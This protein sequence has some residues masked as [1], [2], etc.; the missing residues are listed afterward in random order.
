MRYVLAGMLL[1]LLSGHALGD[2]STGARS[3]DAV[4]KEWADEFQ[5]LDK[6]KK[7]TL[8]GKQRQLAIL[9]DLERAPCKTAQRFLLKLL[10]KR[11]TPGDHRLFALRSLVKMA[12][13]KTLGDVVAALCKAKD[14]TLWQAFG[15]FLGQSNE[16]AVRAWMTGKGLEAKRAD[17]LAACLEGLARRPDKETFA[18]VQ[19]LYAKHADGGDVDV[20]HRAL[21][22]M[23]RTSGADAKES[24]IAASKHEDWRIRLA[25]ADALPPMEPFEGELEAAVRGL[26]QD[27]EAYVRQTTARRAGLAKRKSLA[28]ELKALLSDPRLRTRRIAADALRQVG[29]K[30]TEDVTVPAYHGF[31]VHTDRVVFLV[32]RSSSMTWPWRKKVHRI[33]VALSELQSVLKQLPTDTLF[34]VILFSEKPVFWKKEEVPA[35]PDNAKAAAKWAQKM[36]V[37]PE[38]DT[39]L[40]EALEAA[41]AKNPH[42]DTIFLLTDGDPTAGRYYTE[43]GLAASVRAW[44]RYRRATINTIG[45][46]L[47]LEDVGMP[48][49]SEN[50]HAMEKL[51]KALAAATS[52]SFR[53]IERVPPAK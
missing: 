6:A 7:K 32:D 1:V 5:E 17:V 28:P 23:A 26:L 50:R 30:P 48:N 29:D 46:S 9:E 53:K 19:S 13:E 44:T 8:K 42:F 4:A 41:F 51:M 22:A 16:S 14:A 18:R 3:T 10:K 20:A 36:M 25:A 47:F 35:S 34:N 40:Y 38:G 49:L 24:L 27:E 11:S 52:G 12:D 21:R 2:G 37:E 33:D 31:P 43:E 15:E 45:L 39:Y